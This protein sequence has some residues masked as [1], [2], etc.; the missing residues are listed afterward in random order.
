MTI[1]AVVFG[2]TV[3]ALI[4]GASGIFTEAQSSVTA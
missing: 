2:S 4:A 3:T 1:S